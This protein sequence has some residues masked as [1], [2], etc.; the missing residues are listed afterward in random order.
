MIIFIAFWLSSTFFAGPAQAQKSMIH[1][2]FKKARMNKVDIR[3]E[4]IHNLIIVPVFINNSDTLKFILDTGVSHTMITS[5]RGTYTSSFNFAREINLL[6][7]GQG[8]EVTAYHS[9]GNVIE[10]PGVIG[11]NHNV[12]ILKEEFDF[13][14]QGLGTQVHGLLGFDIFDSF[15]VEIDY[16]TRKLTLYDPNFYGQR[17]RGNIIKKAQVIEMEIVKRKPFVMATVIDENNQELPAKLL[18]DSGASHALTL[19][20]SA[21]QNIDIPDNSIYTFIGVGLSGDIYGYI[22]RAKRFEI[23]DFKFRKP[24]VTYPDEASVQ[25]SNYENERSGSVGADVLKRF[26]VVFDYHR[27]EMILRPNSFFK[28]D[29]TYNL[30]GI[31]L[32]TPF[33]DIPIYQV[34]KI[35]RGSPAWIAGLEVGDQIVTINGIETSEYELSNLVQMLQ[36]RA[37]RTIRV[38]V[39]REDQV[40]QAKFTLEDPIK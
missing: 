20:T 23:G 3:F 31:D 28:D 36:S 4:M 35:R 38:G 7:L 15:T 6:G 32:T 30:S 18:V 19:F 37:G 2:Q 10:L 1:L 17:R 11:F 8:N 13:L 39:K 9:F 24:L 22:G 29:F 21:N 12:I 34:T 33:P 26:T 40:I 27:G 14:S 16:K 25:I 5:M